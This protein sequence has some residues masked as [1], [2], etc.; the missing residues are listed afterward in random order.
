MCVGVCGCVWVLCVW[1]L[2]REAPSFVGNVVRHPL[3]Q[4]LDVANVSWKVYFELL[5]ASWQFQYTRTKLQ[6]YN[7]YEQFAFDAAN[8]NLASYSTSPMDDVRGAYPRVS[9]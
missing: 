8:G 6:N 3:L 9:L 4:D 5:P 2:A 7:L 1:V